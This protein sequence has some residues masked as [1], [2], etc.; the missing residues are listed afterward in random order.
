MA[1]TLEHEQAY[2]ANSVA[3]MA[4]M[5]DP[6]FIRL[7]CDRT[8]SLETSVEVTV[9]ED[10]SSV[11]LSTR[12]LPAK[13]PAA[14][15]SFVGETLTITERQEWTPLSPD[16][17]AT[18]SVSVDFGAPMSFTA[19]M[20]MRAGSSGTVVRTHGSFKA[21]IPFLGGKIEAVAAEQTIRYLDVEEAV[22]NEWLAG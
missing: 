21:S 16:G 13:V 10:G 3:V 15:K 5:Q 4:M 2:A 1:T 12:V 22:G 11:L 8:G 14:A 19:T 7:K 20:S 17:T 9:G 6:D 18:A